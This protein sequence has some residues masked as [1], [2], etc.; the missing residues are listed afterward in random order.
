MIPLQPHSER[1]EQAVFGI[2]NDSMMSCTPYQQWVV[3]IFM[4]LFGVNFNAYYFI[5]LKNVKKALAME[6]VRGYF[7]YTG[8]NRHCICQYTGYVGR[9]A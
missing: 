5:L 9:G 2:K 1:Q 6:E 7:N 8:G 3:T 4:I